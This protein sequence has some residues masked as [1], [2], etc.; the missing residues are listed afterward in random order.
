MNRSMFSRAAA[1]LVV[2]GAAG[3]ASAQTTPLSGVSLR[4]GVFL[5]TNSSASDTGSAWF[6]FGA[7]YRLLR[8]PSDDPNVH[9]NLSI[10]LDWYGKNGADAAPIELDYVAHYEHWFGLVGAGLSF[11]SGFGEDNIHFAYSAGV[12]YDFSVE[13]ALPLFIEAK[14]LGNDDTK[15]DGFGLYAGIRF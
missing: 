1:A 4:A 3:F 7:D 10:S 15:F 11:D 2:V 12:G 8:L 5:P 9:Q 13:P 14:F 6:A